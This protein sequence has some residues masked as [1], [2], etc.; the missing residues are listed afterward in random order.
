MRVCAR[1]I[2]DERVAGIAFDAEGIC[3][4]CDQVEELKDLYGTGSAKGVNKLE[5]VLQRVQHSGRGKKYDCIVGVSGGTDSSFL[6]HWCIEQGLRP[7]AVHYD[8]TWNGSIASSNIRL[9]VEALGVDLYTYVVDN[10]EADDIF[11]AFFLAGVAELEASTDL[12][13]AYVLR[14]IARIEKVRFIFEGHSFVQEGVTPLGRNY[15]DGRYI[16]EIHRLYG[17]CRMK[18][19]PLMTLWRFLYSAIA[20]RVEFVRPLWFIDYSK[21]KAR[22]LL[23]EHYGWR[24]YGGHHLENRMAAF[25]HSV[26]LPQKFGI[27][28]RNNTISARV[29]NGEIP[30]YQGLEEY[31]TPVQV[32]AGLVDFFCQRLGFDQRHYSEI[33]ASPPKS[34][35]EFPT[36]K[37]VFELL[38]PVFRVLADRELV[39]RSF[40]LKYCFPPEGG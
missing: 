35:E 40:Y 37:K 31:A 13:Y 20:T 9:M 29:R 39:T 28:F 36:Y 22:D 12:A 2:Y 14:K 17:T 21:A 25:M 6:L 27:D 4:Y 32:D 5:A 24:D 10:E 34:W 8:N 1:C 33:L 3:N 18:S 30:R 38:R 15:F 16:R 19:Y 11:R 7:L 26:Y 23:E